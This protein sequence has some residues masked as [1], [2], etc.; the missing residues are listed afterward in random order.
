MVSFVFI[1]K[2]FEE[3]GLTGLSWCSAA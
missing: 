3:C 2:L 1:C